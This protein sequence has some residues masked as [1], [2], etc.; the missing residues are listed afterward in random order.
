[1]STSPISRSLASVSDV[2]RVAAGVIM[3][4]HPEVRE[5]RAQLIAV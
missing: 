1:M 3:R 2:S 4:I 5:R